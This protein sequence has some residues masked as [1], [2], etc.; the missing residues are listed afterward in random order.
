MALQSI[1]NQVYNRI[2]KHKRGKLFFPSDF[3]TVGSVLAIN[4][5]LSRLEKEQVIERL[6]QGI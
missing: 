4:T 3:S 1:H 6:A 5:A 2:T